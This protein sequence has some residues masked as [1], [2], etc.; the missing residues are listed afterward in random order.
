MRGSPMK[1][2]G[3]VAEMRDTAYWTSTC[4]GEGKGRGQGARTAPAQSSRYQQD[5]PDVRAAFKKGVG[6]RRLR[7][8]SNSAGAV[9]RSDLRRCIFAQIN[10]RLVHIA[11]PPSLGRII[12][13]DDR[14]LCSPEMP[15]RMLT[16]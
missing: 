15:G 2:S 9:E 1:R 6:L 5:L 3:S 16:G 12:S 11:P 10:Q 14:M 13:L 8:L 7:V 4:R